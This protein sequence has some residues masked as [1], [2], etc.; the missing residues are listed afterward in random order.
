MSSLLPGYNYDIFTSYCQKGN[1]VN[2]ISYN[3]GI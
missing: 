2:K 1:K 3:F